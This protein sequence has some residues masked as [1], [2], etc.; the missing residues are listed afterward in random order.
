MP[1][2][3]TAAVTFGRSLLPPTNR[4]RSTGMPSASAA[5][6]V[7]AVKTPVPNSETPA[8]TTAVPSL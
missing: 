4:T 5:T 1:A 6:W 2:D 3:P 8:S 7:I